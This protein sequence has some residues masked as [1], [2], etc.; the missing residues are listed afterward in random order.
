MTNTQAADFISCMCISCCGYGMLM[1]ASSSRSYKCSSKHRALET[2]VKRGKGNKRQE[3]ST[4]DDC[5]PVRRHA[6]MT[7][8]C[9]CKTGIHAIHGNNMVAPK[10]GP[11][12]GRLKRVFAKS[13][14]FGRYRYYNLRRLR[15]R[16]SVSF[17]MP[18][19]PDDVANPFL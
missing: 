16:E 7:G 19:G 9:S 17:R 18:P 12:R 3:T 1:P 13:R 6:A 4:T 2:Q 8:V 11:L 14:P 15:W 10:V 5:T